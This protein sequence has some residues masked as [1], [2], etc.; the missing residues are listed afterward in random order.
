[1]AGVGQ[2]HI[3]LH[4]RKVAPHNH[5]PAA[6]HGDK[7][8]P[9]RGGLVHGH[10]LETVHGGIQGL[11][12][13]NLRDDHPGAQAGGPHGHALPAP[14]VP[15][16]HH[17]LAGHHQVGG[18]HDAVPDRLPGAVF[19]VIIMLGLGVVDRHHGAGQDARLLPGLQTKDAGGGLLTAA[20][21]AVRVRLALAP[22]QV[23]QVPAVIN[24]QVGVALQGLREVL[25]VLLRAGPVDAKGLH[26]HGR[27]A[28]GHVILGGQGVGTGQIDFR[29]PLLE[30][31][32]QVG[33]L[34]LQMDR[35]RHTEPLK[36]FLPQK[37]GL[38]L[39]QRGHKVPDPL[40]LFPAGFR[41]RGIF[42]N[43]HLLPL[44]SS[45]SM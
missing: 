17:S 18:V 21:Q 14:A 36:G 35:H 2:E 13:V 26:P 5:V 15:G 10:H 1:M 39:R 42:N 38:N 20:D 40:N 28:G 45:H 41:Q 7:D 22:Q 16:H 29:A 23:D 4:G 27:Q 19:V 24:D 31:I 44:L 32:A 33:G 25:L 8:V 43:A 37:P 12:G 9:Q 6:G 3:V 11:E 34:C 30:H